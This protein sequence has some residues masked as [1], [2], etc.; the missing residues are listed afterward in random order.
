VNSQFEFLPGAL[1]VQESP[2]SPAGR[3]L[4]WLLVL[5]FSTAV[6]WACLGKVDIVVTSVGRVVP[7][8]QVK[9]VQAPDS[10]VVSAIHVV[11]GQRVELGQA[12]L[13]LDNTYTL[14]DASQTLERLNH[15]R[16]EIAWR[17]ALKLWLDEENRPLA[18]GGESSLVGGS[19]IFGQKKKEIEAKI[20]SLQ[21]EL[22]AS[23][24]EKGALVAERDRS[25]STLA[26][27]KQRVNAYRSLMESQNAARIQYLEI[28]QQQTELEKSLPVLELRQRQLASRSASL[29][30]RKNSVLG[31]IRNQ[32]L[33]ELT[34]L[35]SERTALEQEYRK[36]QRRQGLRTIQAPVTGTVQELGIHTLGGVVQ[37]A[38][39]LMKIVPEDAEI[40]VEAL[41]RN[42]DIGF[43]ELGQAAAVKIDAFNF[44]KYGLLDAIVAN[45]SNDAI[46]D[47]QH[48]WVYKARLALPSSQLKVGDRLI[49]PTP[50]MSVTA[51]I[52]TG[53]RRLIEFFLSPLLRHKQESIRE[54]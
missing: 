14:A 9:I 40:E 54:R 3:L 7:S 51:E 20:L 21:K 16:G 6:I 13:R 38:Q 19:E 15:L 29:T 27:L 33:V 23:E 41:L 34:R 43:V 48:G 31:E 4:L 46:E 52:T 47:Q 1:E 25:Q 17:G 2:P 24:A 28:L 42:R 12:L 10:G 30:A 18:A 53:T 36:A 11:E 22:E 39:Q 44:T 32:N 49:T 5:L 26:V 37:A 8:G 35:Q 50:G 45:I